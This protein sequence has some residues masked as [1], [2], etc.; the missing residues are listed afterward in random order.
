MISKKISEKPCNTCGS[1]KKGKLA[2]IIEGWGNYFFPNEE[3]EKIAKYRA[4]RCATCDFNKFDVCT[5]CVGVG[6][7]CPIAMKTRSMDEECPI[8]RW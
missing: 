2:R 3:V 4:L 7:G 1:N 6:V 5:K 8:D